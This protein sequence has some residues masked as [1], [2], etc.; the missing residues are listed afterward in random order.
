MAGTLR[1]E[2]MAIPGIEGAELDGDAETPA[3][4]RVRLGSR[5]TQTPTP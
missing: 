2:L 3:G 1:D 4:V 5:S